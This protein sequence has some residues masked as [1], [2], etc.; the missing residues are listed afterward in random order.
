MH[1]YDKVFFPLV[2]AKL[3]MMSVPRGLHVKSLKN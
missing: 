3:D 2:V 1:N